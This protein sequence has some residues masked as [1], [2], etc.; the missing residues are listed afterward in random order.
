[1][2]IIGNNHILLR[3]SR[4]IL[5]SSHQARAVTLAH[6]GHQGHA[7]TTACLRESVWFPGI[8]QCVKEQVGKCIACQATSQPNLPELMQSTPMHS[9]A[10]NEL[11]IDFCGPFPLGI[12]ILAVIDVYSRNPEIEILK[13]NSAPKVIP[14]LDIIFTIHGIPENVTTDNGPPFNGKAWFPYSLKVP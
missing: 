6:E 5:P 3:G 8:G 1:M 7:R 11:E 10:W 12:Y 2:T 4:I 14:M 13:S 9:P